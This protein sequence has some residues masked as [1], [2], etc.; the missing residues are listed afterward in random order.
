MRIISSA[1]LV[2]VMMLMSF[3]VRA[4]DPAAELTDRLE[5][6]RSLSADF[7]Q[8]IQDPSGQKVQE[9]QGVMSLQKPGRFYWQA[10]QPFPQ[11][12]VSDGQTLWLYDPDLEQV[13]IRPMDERVTHTPALLLSGSAK[14]LTQNFEVSRDERSGTVSY[15]L[16][17]TTEDTL[18]EVLRMS[19]KQDRLVSIQMEDS[20]GQRTLVELH[21]V[22]YNIDIPAHRFDF[23]IPDG[24]DVIR[25]QARAGEGV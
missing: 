9:T 5:S 6:L 7:V 11:T 4:A 13:T 15:T 3:A 8:L 21:D 17:P 20:L 14:A 25:E 16:R 12:L 1:L 18:F 19:F 10:Q 2:T 22:Q 24:V 23:E